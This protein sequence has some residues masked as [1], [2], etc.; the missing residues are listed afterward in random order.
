MHADTYEQLSLIILTCPGGRLGKICRQVFRHRASG[1]FNDLIADRGTLLRIEMGM[2]L[3][4]IPIKRE[5]H[6]A[7]RLAGAC[8]RKSIAGARF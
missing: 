7:L 5:G 8:W 6:A 2:R 4:R 3:T 1:T